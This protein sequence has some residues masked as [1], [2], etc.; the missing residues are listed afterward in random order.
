MLCRP[1]KFHGSLRSPV[2]SSPTSPLTVYA[3]GGGVS[4]YSHCWS[5]LCSSYLLFQGKSDGLAVGAPSPASPPLPMIPPR[6]PVIR[7][8]PPGNSQRFVC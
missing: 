5:I 7:Q 6:P 3:V 4:G 2:V 1:Q 8:Q